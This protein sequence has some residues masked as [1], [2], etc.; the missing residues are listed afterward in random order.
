[1]LLVRYKVEAE[2]MSVIEVDAR[3]T[4]KR[5]ARCGA[6]AGPAAAAISSDA[7]PAGSRIKPMDIRLRGI[8]RWQQPD[9]DECP[10]WCPEARSVDAGSKPE[11]NAGKSATADR[12]PAL[13]GGS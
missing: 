9:Q 13:A 3:D 11:E 7:R 4:S 1:M 2:G 12:S 6:V 10:S 8:R 5:C